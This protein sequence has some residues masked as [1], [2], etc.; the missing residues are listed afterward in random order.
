MG[1]ENPIQ[2]SNFNFLLASYCNCSDYQSVG[3]L[4]L[5]FSDSEISNSTLV[6]YLKSNGLIKKAIFSLYLSN[7]GFD[8]DKS[9]EARSS[10]MLGGYDKDKYADDSDD[11]IHYHDVQDDSQHWYLELS[12]VRFSSVTF[13]DNTD[14]IVDPGSKYLYGPDQYVD[15]IRQFIRLRHLC[16]TDDGKFKCHCNDYENFRDITFVFDGI[17]YDIGAKWFVDKDNGIC[18]IHIYGTNHERWILGQIFLRKY[19]SVWDYEK[20]RI[21]FIKSINVSDSSS[22]SAEAWVVIVVVVCTLCVLIGSFVVL[23]VIYK[24]KKTYRNSVKSGQY[25]AIRIN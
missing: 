3:V 22:S 16:Y 25:S 19:Y 11:S 24:K 23:I 9:P 15:R 1:D 10:L 5:G 8:D 2:V 7:T 18:T 12:E 17:D 14:A 13:L 6:K 4:G 20:E 21:G